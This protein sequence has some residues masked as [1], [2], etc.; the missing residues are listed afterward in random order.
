MNDKIFYDRTERSSTTLKISAKAMKEAKSKYNT[1]ENMMDR[2]QVINKKRAY[3][4]N[5]SPYA[6]LFTEGIQ[7]YVL[8]LNPGAI[9]VHLDDYP[10]DYWFNLTDGEAFTAEDVSNCG[11][12]VGS[13]FLK[14]QNP[15]DEI[16][17]VSGALYKEGDR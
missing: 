14:G 15:Q 6:F 1:P 16:L 17:E 10:L 5:S 3:L 13:Y 9:L 12:Y 4:I 11:Y 7:A 2:M 8:G